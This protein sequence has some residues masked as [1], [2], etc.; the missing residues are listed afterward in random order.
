MR[1]ALR[2]SKKFER[3]TGVQDNGIELEASGDIATAIDEFVLRI[4]HFG[5]T[6]CIGANRIFHHYYVAG[7]THRIIRFLQ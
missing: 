5:G 4:D 7:T 3:Q 6:N 2:A 1:K